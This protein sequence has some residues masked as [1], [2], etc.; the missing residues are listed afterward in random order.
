[1]SLNFTGRACAPGVFLFVFFTSDGSLPICSCCTTLHISQG[2]EQTT[3]AARCVGVRTV[4][5]LPT[6]PAGGARL[7]CE[8]RM[9]SEA[10]AIILICSCIL[11][12]DL[13]CGKGLEGATRTHFGAVV[14]GHL[15][16]LHASSRLPR[17]PTRLGGRG[18]C[19]SRFSSYSAH[20]HQ[21][22]HD[23]MVHASTTSKAGMGFVR[24][25]D[26]EQRSYTPTHHPMGGPGRS[27]FSSSIFSCGT[28]RYALEKCSD[29]STEVSS[30]LAAVAEVFPDDRLARPTPQLPQRT[31]LHDKVRKLAKALP[32]VGALGLT[33]SNITVRHVS[34]GRG[35]SCLLPSNCALAHV[36]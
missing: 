12:G 34:A 26:P 14:L 19:G 23:L 17:A 28:W 33:V 13:F 30:S 36:Q 31:P 6:W 25:E 11:D 15:Q 18:G 20:E 29:V 9:R 3:S 22:G 21:S 24:V 27:N 7:Q 4:S 5:S 8:E 10:H 16:Q 1:M 32:C 2:V 35:C